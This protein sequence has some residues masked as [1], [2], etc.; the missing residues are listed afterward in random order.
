MTALPPPTLA[1]KAD[2]LA[3]KIALIK[4]ETLGQL[5]DNRTAMALAD[6]AEI[7]AKREIETQRWES[8]SN[9]RNRVYHFSSDVTEGTVS[10]ALDVLTRWHRLDTAEG[11]E[12]RYVFV[13]C[14]PGGAVVPGMKLHA[15]LSSIAKK[16]EV[17]TIASG[18]CASMGTIIHQ[19]GT[20]RIIEP[21]ASYMIHDVSGGAMGSLSDMKD[22]LEYMEKLNGVMHRMLS[23]RSG[24]T[25]EEIKEL[26][27]RKDAWFNADETV[28]EGFA[29]EVGL[30]LDYQ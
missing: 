16:R 19:A 7:N 5:I 14:T 12:G 29:D 18:F 17:I 6:T 1:T 26:S 3:A 15:L 8:A 22:T 27:K 24:K 30:A 4:S 21:G 9:S 20:K 2:V 25:I 28:A 13:L 11:N 23:E 10:N